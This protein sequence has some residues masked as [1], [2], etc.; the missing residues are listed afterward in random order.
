MKRFIYTD[1]G[2]DYVQEKEGNYICTVYDKIMITQQLGWRWSHKRVRSN[3]SSCTIDPYVKQWYKM[4]LGTSLFPSM[5]KCLA[6]KRNHRAYLLQKK[7]MP[8]MRMNLDWKRKRRTERNLNWSQGCRGP[9]SKHLRMQAKQW[10]LLQESSPL[11]I[12]VSI[13]EVL[14]GMESSISAKF[15]GKRGFCNGT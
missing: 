15:I 11:M 12:T 5:V 3:Q 10:H 9:I 6:D 4:E 13:H 7:K 1:G 2:G 14:Y 8:R